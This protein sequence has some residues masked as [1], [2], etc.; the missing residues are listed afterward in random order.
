MLN[1]FF[2]HLTRRDQHHVRKLQ[3]RVTSKLW[4]KGCFTPFAFFFES[5]CMSLSFVAFSSYL[6]PKHECQVGPSVSPTFSE[7]NLALN[8]PVS[9]NPMISL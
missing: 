5:I 3:Y 2:R 4:M 9:S 6:K 1:P 8:P 7:M